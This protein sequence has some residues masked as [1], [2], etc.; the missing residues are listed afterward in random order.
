VAKK[1]TVRREMAK[2][3]GREKDI[4]GKKTEGGGRNAKES[5]SNSSPGS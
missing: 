1:K 2:K 3:E 5:L 4:L